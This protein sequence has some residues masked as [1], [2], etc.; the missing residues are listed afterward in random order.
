MTKVTKNSSNKKY[1][2]KNRRILL[3]IHDNPFSF[4][5]LRIECS[6]MLRFINGGSEDTAI[7]YKKNVN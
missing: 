2:T 5:I 3:I 7:L 1:I 6:K 4:A